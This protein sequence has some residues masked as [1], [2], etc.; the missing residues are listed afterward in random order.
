MTKKPTHKPPPWKAQLRMQKLRIDNLFPDKTFY[1]ESIWADWEQRIDKGH[2]AEE[3]VLR[4]RVKTFDAL[5]DAMRN[6]VQESAVDDYGRTCELTY[7][8]RAAVVVCLWSN[9]ES[10][11]KEI[12]LVYCKVLPQIPNKENPFGMTELIG[13]CRKNLRTKLDSV[14]NYPVINA[15][16]ILNNAYK[17]NNSFYQHSADKPWENIDAALL[18][19]WGIRKNE[20]V[21]FTNI[22]LKELT[23][24]PKAFFHELLQTV[25]EELT[26]KCPKAN[27]PCS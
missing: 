4:E 23:T 17:H 20:Q 10:F 3:S 5:P 25:Q 27:A 26:A 15:I 2:K 1:Y 6:E 24:A 19:D 22:P 18:H 11:F 13:F 12:I 7:N 16:R 8:M 14:P 9:I 21:D